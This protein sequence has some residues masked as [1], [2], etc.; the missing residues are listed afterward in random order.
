ML[1]LKTKYAYDV[2]QIYTEARMDPLSQFLSGFGQYP[3]HKSKLVRPTY[4]SQIQLPDAQSILPRGYGK[5]YGDA[6]INADGV[7]LLTECLNRFITFDDVQG[8]LTLEAGCTLHDVLQ[9][10]LPRGWIL[11]VMPGTAHVSVGGCI[12]NDVHGKNHHH[13]GAF[14]ACVLSFELLTAN[15]DVITCSREQHTDLF[16][17]TIAGLGLTGIILRATLQLESCPSAYV[18]SQHLPTQDLQTTLAALQN[19]ALDD[20]YSIAWIDALATGSSLGRGVYMRG[21]MADSEKDLPRA[22][23]SRHLPS[24]FPNFCL[25]KPL[26]QLFNAIYREANGKKT[27]PFTQS[28]QQFFFPLDAIDNWPV[29]YGK[30]G[31]QQYQFV[32]PEDGAESAIRDALTLLQKNNIPVYLA[33]LK[34]LGNS[35]QSPLSFP[36]PGYTLALDVSMKHPNILDCFNQLD[37]IVM[38]HHGRVYLAKDARL[39]QTAFKTMYPQWETWLDLK[40]QWDPAMKFRST[41]FS[42]IME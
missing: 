19:S 36:M 5:S 38:Q 20:H 17:A 22:H 14:S 30:C 39:P 13:A 28:Y 31:M 26:G 29:L 8:L 7:T 34:R 11:P 9:F 41:L 21:H 4:A 1:D 23:S 12:A 6:A 40:K 42:R 32:V 3:K 33:T 18:S 2:E 37:A 10:A 27:R 16:W 35:N 15:N 24:I 25:N